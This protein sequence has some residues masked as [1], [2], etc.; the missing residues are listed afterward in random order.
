M[1]ED[2]SG[3]RRGRDLPSPRSIEAY[4][5]KK[6]WHQ[7]GSYGEIETYWNDRSTHELTVPSREASSETFAI[8]IRHII[9]N[10]AR[11]QDT[12]EEY[13]SSEV[14][15]ADR[16]MVSFATIE[17]PIHPRQM[18]TLADVSTSIMNLILQ[19]SRFTQPSTIHPLSG[20]FIS[21]A[22]I[23]SSYLSRGVLATVFPSIRGTES[24]L[25]R[26]F[27]LCSGMLMRLTAD[28]TIETY[29]RDALFESHFLTAANAIG[30]LSL[31]QRKLTFSIPARPDYE[32]TLPS[33]LLEIERPELVAAEVAPLP[34]LGEPSRF[35]G[36]VIQ[37]KSTESRGGGTATVETTS[38][39]SSS[40]ARPRRIRLQLEADDYATAVIAHLERV[41]VYVV[42][43]LTLKG[44]ALWAES[45]LEFGFVE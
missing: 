41:K 15:I 28:E 11:I 12:P 25:Q 13:V 20:S 29:Q 9:S 1:N 26:S 32:V 19:L 33:R 8:K 39:D 44:R 21:H 37:L 31:E 45:V 10:L 43:Q 27:E 38:L 17:R 23:E 14:R 7:V 22:Y 16:F 4:L 30:A 40:F 3:T 5:L 18:F 34:P 24:T 35:G 2:G 6:G 36:N 42:A